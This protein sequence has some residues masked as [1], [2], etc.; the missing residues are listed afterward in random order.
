MNVI[1]GDLVPGATKAGKGCYAD[2]NG[3][4]YA[5]I[6]GKAVVDSENEATV[7]YTHDCSR[8]RIPRVNDLVLCRVTKVTPR[9]AGVD[10]VGV[11]EDAGTMTLKLTKLALPWKATI[12]HQDAY[13]L[14][15]RDPPAIYD[16]FMPT[17]LVKGQVIGFGDHSTGLLVSTGLRDDFGVVQAMSVNDF[18]LK[19]VAWNEMVCPLT[20][21]IERRKVAKPAI[22]E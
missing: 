2:S 13:A 14:E 6:I 17:D 12:R 1:P 20:G 19:P 7:V 5:S 16:S 10:V 18:L 9:F 15:E 8:S 11:F 3:H 22:I 21:A 4:V